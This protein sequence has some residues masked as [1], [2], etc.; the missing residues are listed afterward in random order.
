MRNDT[1]FLTFVLPSDLPAAR[2]M[3]ASLRAFGGELA[4]APMWV[5]ST[6][7]EQI[8]SLE[9]QDTRL[10]LLGPMPASPC[11]FAEKVAACARAEELVPAGTRALVWIDPGCLVV[12]PPLGFALGSDCDAA[13][14]PV[15]VRNVGLPPSEPLDPFWQGICRAVGVED[16]HSR[17]TSFVDGQVLRSY[18]NSHAFAINPALGL[19]RGW[20]ERFRLLIDDRSF[21]AAACADD[22]HQIFLFQA[23]LSALVVR[24]I[25]PARF[26]LLP[27]TYNYPCHLQARVPAERRITALNDLVCFAYEELDPGSLAGFEVHDP[28]RAW[29]AE[30]AQARQEQP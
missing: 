8:A 30:Q 11:L 19:L 9:D 2:L 6:Q 14:R 21:Q 26:R 16:I 27:P 17:V 15:H 18:F 28:L 3:I 10:H 24:S 20:Q 25:E 29:L 5:F 7:P 23:L 22:L 4:G 1:L 13:F 12:Q